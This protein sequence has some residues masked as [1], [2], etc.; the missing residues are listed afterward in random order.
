MKVNSQAPHP[1]SHAHGP[2]N[3]SP[4]ADKGRQDGMPM[5]GFKAATPNGQ[6]LNKVVKS[7]FGP[8]SGKGPEG[9]GNGPE[10]MKEVFSNIYKEVTQKAEEAQNPKLKERYQNQADVLK[11]M[12]SGLSAVDGGSPGGVP[13]QQG[14]GVQDPSGAPSGP[15]NEQLRQV[16]TELYTDNMQQATEAKNPERREHYMDQAQIIKATM[17]IMLP[18]EP[19][20]MGEGL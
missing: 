14:P 4:S 10:K 18:P 3:A 19:A 5:N 6:D 12:L 16:F 2:A 8:L 20:A 11:T 13:G 7:P 9:P 1:A 17:E 15:G